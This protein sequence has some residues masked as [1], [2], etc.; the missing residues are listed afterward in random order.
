MTPTEWIA[1]SI[2]GGAYCGWIWVGFCIDDFDWDYGFLI[3]WTMA[4]LGPILLTAFALTR[5]IN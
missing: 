1:F 3:P 2:C 4:G 5:F